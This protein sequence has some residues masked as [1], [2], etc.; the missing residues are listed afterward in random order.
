M[1]FY[2]AGSR[3]AQAFVWLVRLL[4]RLRLGNWVAQGRITFYTTEMGY[5]LMR[6]TQLVRW[7]LFTG[8]AGPTRKMTL[9]YN[10]KADKSFFLK[11]DLAPPVAANL[12][13]ET[14]ALSYSQSGIPSFA[15]VRVHA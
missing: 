7:A 6:R 10:T 15:P 8:T 11:I 5:S 14:L 13:Q 9:W 12:R 4:F 1:R 3:R 2:S